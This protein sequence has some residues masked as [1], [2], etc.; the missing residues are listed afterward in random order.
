MEFQYFDFIITFEFTSL[1]QILDNY[2][3]YSKFINSF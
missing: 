3:H 2:T 1:N